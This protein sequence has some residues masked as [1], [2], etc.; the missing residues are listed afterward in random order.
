MKK[1]LITGGAGFIGSSL[2]IKLKSNHKVHV[3][4][5]KRKINKI[6]SKL[7]GC[8]T[9][10]GDIKKVSSFKK[11]DKDYDLVFHLAAKT[12]SSVA[13]SQ[14]DECFENNVIGAYN[15]INWINEIKPKCLV[16]SSS[17]SVY[18][19]IANKI[20]ENYLCKPISVYGK[21][22]L[23]GEKIFKVMTNIETKL[24][25]LRLFNVYG[26]NQDFNNLK[27]GMLS[28]YLAQIYK[29]GKVF[30]TG[31]LKRYRDFVFVDDVVKALMNYNKFKNKNVYNV[32]TG[33]KIKVNFL[34]NKIF[35]SLKKNPKNNII[36]SKSSY[37]DTWGSYA[38]IKKSKNSGWSPKINLEEGLNKT[39]KNII[40]NFS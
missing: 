27:Q 29:K 32:G 5:F 31:S 20:S 7:K 28:I 8:K 26:P 39:I 33:K 14:P 36:V 10:A 37:G 19:R 25:I 23:L 12:S 9:I 18:G 6:K 13:E 40:K 30:V 21:S 11:L 17:M 15:L 22:K 16:F 4:D 3:F 1:V 34:I 38:N 2:A 35:K 24:V